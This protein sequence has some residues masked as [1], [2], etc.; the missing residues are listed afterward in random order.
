MALK[1]GQ[2]SWCYLRVVSNLSMLGGG[3]WCLKS[4]SKKKLD[5]KTWQ[6][7][8]FGKWRAGT[9]ISRFGLGSRLR[10]RSEKTASSPPEKPWC[11]LK[12]N[13]CPLGARLKFSGAFA[14]KFPGSLSENCQH[15]TFWGVGFGLEGLFRLVSSI[16][17]A[18]QSAGRQESLCLCISIYKYTW[19]YNFTIMLIW[20]FVG[21]CDNAVT[22]DRTC[23]WKP[24]QTF[25][26][27]KL[28]G[29]AGEYALVN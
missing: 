1:D 4:F 8:P 10:A 29:A 17:Y 26:L 16:L 19:E 2:R 9:P 18:L 13:S 6:Y 11:D 5:P 28:A 7:I 21:C 27:K 25:L 3:S 20:L 24:N 14:V 15:Q 22:N 12:W 23:T